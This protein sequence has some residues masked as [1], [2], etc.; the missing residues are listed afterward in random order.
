MIM[1]ELCIIE[2]LWQ[3][4]I[5][6]KSSGIIKKSPGLWLQACQI[7]DTTQPTNESMNQ[8][9]FNSCFLVIG[10]WVLGPIVPQLGF[11]YR[12]SYLSRLR[13]EWSADF[14]PRVPRGTLDF[15]N[16]M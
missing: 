8:S 14:P 2:K 6:L 10:A 5:A 11:A 13:V 7:L 12:G 9:T 1:M 16:F 4:K 3:L 15:E